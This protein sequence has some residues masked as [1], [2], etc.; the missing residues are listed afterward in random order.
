MDWSLIVPPGHPL[1]RKRKLALADLCDE[2]L[3]VYERGST[4]RQHVMEAFQ[5]QGIAP[6][7]ELE[8]TNTDLIVRMVEAK[9]GVAIVPL[10]R[11]GAVTRGRKVA[12]RSLGHQIRPI[13]SGVLLRKGERPRPAVQKLLGFLGLGT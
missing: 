7:V 11:S 3:I 10:Y 13:H 12:A 9:L 6:Q 4:G 2:H 1:A 8:A 5:S